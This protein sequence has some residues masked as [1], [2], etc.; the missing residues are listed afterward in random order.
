MP[1]SIRQ[2]AYFYTTVRDRPGKAYG[3]LSR[4]SAAGVNLLA[5]NAVPA[6]LEQTQLVLFPEDVELL[7]QVATERNLELAGPHHALLIQGDDELGALADIHRRLSDLGINVSA[8]SGVADGGGG[9]GYIVYVRAEDLPR[10]AEA[11]GI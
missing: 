7:S 6:G 9:Y 1:H 8:A 10:A 3:L 2:V 11:L 5:F 4:L